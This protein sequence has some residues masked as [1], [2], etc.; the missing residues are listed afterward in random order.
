MREEGKRGFSATAG[1]DKRKQSE[2]RVQAE[3]PDFVAGLAVG[4]ALD[5]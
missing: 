5:R 1:Q 4:R 3:I 2:A